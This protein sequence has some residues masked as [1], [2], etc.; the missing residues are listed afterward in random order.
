MTEKAT[1]SF[2]FAETENSIWKIDFGLPSHDELVEIYDYAESFIVLK[3]IAAGKNFCITG[4]YRGKQKIISPTMLNK[5][6]TVLRAG[7]Q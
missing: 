4:K 1:R 3:N 5:Q 2:T 7:R 6:F